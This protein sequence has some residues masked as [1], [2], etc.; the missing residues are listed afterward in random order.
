V[1]QLRKPLAGSL[2]ATLSS[3]G[4]VRA[5][6]YNDVGILLREDGEGK[7][8][9]YETSQILVAGLNCRVIHS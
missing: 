3:R 2:E 9:F 7:I 4:T 5:K 8:S 1:I 6:T